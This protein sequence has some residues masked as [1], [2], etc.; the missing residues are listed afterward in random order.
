M[1]GHNT[2][3]KDKR[4]CL[5]NTDFAKIVREQNGRVFNT[6]HSLLGNEADAEDVAQ[7]VFLRAYRSMGGFRGESDISTWLYRITMNT[8]TDHLRKNGSNS[9]MCEPLNAADQETLR[10]A[11][12]PD[13]NP[14]NLYCKKELNQAILKALGALPDKL[15]KVF[16]LK[17]VDGYL[18]KDIGKIL[19]ISM[20]TVKSR[21]SRARE[22][23]RN[24]LMRSSGN[25]GD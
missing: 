5:R 4:S 14:E 16:V 17:E 2:G 11:F 12:R 15:R 19:G 22:I 23:L 25:S 24:E 18:Y 3:M 7:E 6:V 20:G 9:R 21:L 8:V 10:L 13:E 1:A